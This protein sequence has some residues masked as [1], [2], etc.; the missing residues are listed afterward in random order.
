M[1]D[2]LHDRLETI[3]NACEGAGSP[4]SFL[5]AE[6]VSD[7][8]HSTPEEVRE[9]LNWLAAWEAPKSDGRSSTV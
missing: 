4:G 9:I 1:N 5:L 8:A 6:L 2:N 7:V 3:L